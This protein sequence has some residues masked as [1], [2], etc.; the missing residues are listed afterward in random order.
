MATDT[1][2]KISSGFFDSSVADDPAVW[3]IF[4]AMCVLS[5]ADGV[6]DIRVSE[7]ARRTRKTAEEVQAAV[8]K[9]SMPDPDSRS[10]LS[11][12]QRVL[13][14]YRDRPHG[15][16]IVNKHIYND[17]GRDDSRN[18]LAVAR[19]KARDVR[20][21]GHRTPYQA[22]AQAKAQAEE[23]SNGHPEPVQPDPIEQQ[24]FPALAGLMGEAGR[25]A[26][27]EKRWLRYPRKEKRRR[28]LRYFLAS[29]QTIEELSLLDQALDAYVPYAERKA[30]LD[31][32]LQWIPL[33]GTWFGDWRDY[34]PP[35]QPPEL[36]TT[37]ERAVMADLQIGSH[38]AAPPAEDAADLIARRAE[39]EGTLTAASRWIARHGLA[40]L[41]MP[42][43]DQTKLRES[44]AAQAAVVAARREFQ[45]AVGLSWGRWSALEAEFE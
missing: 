4:L 24:A 22:K 15:W 14:L 39:Y 32:T 27:F 40:A 25:I 19:S 26:E 10:K 45:E 13:P 42:P 36:R 33:G 12:G 44:M 20:L 35:W 29:V 18:P 11:N 28:A 8:Q 3:P 30:A 6:L 34:A 37:K 16:L 41:E 21:A 38:A 23:K 1:Y 43:W 7:L 31:G 17:L 9:L 5:D 2:A